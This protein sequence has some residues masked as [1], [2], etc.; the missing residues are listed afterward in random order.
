MEQETS[1]PSPVAN[2]FIK[3]LNR[4][5]ITLGLAVVV[6]IGAGVGYYIYTSSHQSPQQAQQKEIDSLV[7][8]VGKLMVLPSDEQPVIATVADPAKLKDQPFFANA[9]VGSK[10]LIY[11]KAKKAILYD[12][13]GGRII[14]VAPL[15]LNATPTP[16]K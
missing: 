5:T 12:P 16:T 10:V 1:S 4:R 11:N 2:G 8:A 13:V 3:R 6:V 9:K 15:S 14:D 7:A